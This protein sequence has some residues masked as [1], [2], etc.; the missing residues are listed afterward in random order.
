VRRNASSG[1]AVALLA[2]LLE[3]PLNRAAI[4]QTQ[5]GIVVT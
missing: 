3:S 2:D 5:S 1:A 4:Q